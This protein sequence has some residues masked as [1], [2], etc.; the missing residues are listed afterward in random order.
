M[1]NPYIQ[2]TTPSAQACSFRMLQYDGLTIP[3]YV[4]RP[5]F[6]LSMPGKMLAHSQIHISLR[7]WRAT[8]GALSLEIPKS[9]YQERMLEAHLFGHASQVLSRTVWPH[10]A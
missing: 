8:D 10:V 7:Y 2:Y 3:G 4:V 5:V 6:F 9:L 1:R